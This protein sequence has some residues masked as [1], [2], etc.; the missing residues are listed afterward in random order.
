MTWE[1]Q[2]TTVSTFNISPA[3]YSTQPVCP[4]PREKTRCRSELRCRSTPRCNGRTRRARTADGDC[5]RCDL[6]TIPQKLQLLQTSPVSVQMRTKIAGREYRCLVSMHVTLFVTAQA[7]RVNEHGCITWSPEV[8]THF[9]S[10]TI[11]SVKRGE[12]FLPK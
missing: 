4:L 11:V 8:A 6:V 9:P 5:A 2:V 12:T 1:F 7:R 10:R 3:Q